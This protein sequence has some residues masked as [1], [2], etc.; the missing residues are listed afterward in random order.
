MPFSLAPSRAA[1]RLLAPAGA[2]AGALAL[3]ACGGGDG[4]T[5]NAPAVTQTLSIVPAPSSTTLPGLEGKQLSVAPGDTVRLSGQLTDSRGGTTMPTL[6][7]RSSDAGVAEVDATGLLR[8]RIAGTASIIATADRHADTLRVVVSNCG[9]ARAV[10][11]KV[12][13]VQAFDAGQGMDLCVIGGAAT[14]EYALIPFYATDSA[15]RRVTVAVTANGMGTAV[16]ADVAPIAAGPVLSRTGGLSASRAAVGGAVMTDAP[17]HRRLH[18]LGARELTSSRVAGA[19]ETRR[20]GRADAFARRAARRANLSAA[21]SAS[22]A[23]TSS[24]ASASTRPRAAT[25]ASPPP[26]RSRR[27]SSRCRASATCCA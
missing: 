13:Q 23:P 20:T 7:W 1:L 10:D 6:S 14:Q 19:R 17:L 15:S 3:A 22:S 26:R 12:G 4:P 2:W 9:S 8:A 21:P 24:S 27:A 5:G 18:A 11:L 25:P 16:G